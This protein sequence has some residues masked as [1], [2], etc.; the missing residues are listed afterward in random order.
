MPLRTRQ[1]QSEYQR[2]WVKRR[3]EVWVRAHGPCAECG[4]WE[5]P[6]I[7]HVDPSTKQTSVAAVWSWS[8]AKRDRELAKCQ[9]LCK[10][11][12]RRKTIASLLRNGGHNLNGYRR[13]CRCAICTT[14]VREKARRYRQTRGVAA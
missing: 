4:S 7:D 14:A 8:K 9:V 5:Q 1:E 10:P 2:L 12:H 11:C 3:R 13:G 6:E